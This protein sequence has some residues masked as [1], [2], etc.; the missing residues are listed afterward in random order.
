MNQRGLAIGVVVFMGCGPAAAPT[1]PTTAA[2]STATASSATPP[3]TSATPRVEAKGPI[4]APRILAPI[5]GAKVHTATPSVTVGLAAD[6]DAAEIE[7]C[8][9][10]ACATSLARVTAMKKDG[11]TSASMKALQPGR[12]YVRARG[13]RAGVVGTDASAA[14]PFAV[15][16]PLGSVDTSELSFFEPTAAELG[17]RY[18]DAKSVVAIGDVDGDGFSDAVGIPCAPGKTDCKAYALLPGGPNA[19]TVPLEGLTG[20]TWIAVGDTN[21]DGFADAVV[22]DGPRGSFVAGGAHGFG[23]PKPI[24]PA[25]GI[26]VR[27]PQGWDLNG[28]GFMDYVTAK[29]PGASGLL[30]HLG[31]VRGPAEAPTELPTGVASYECL[32]DSLSAGDINGDGYTDLAVGAYCSGAGRAYVFL[33]G[34]ALDPKPAYTLTQPASKTKVPSRFGFGVV[35]RDADH[36]GIDDLY[37]S[38]GC[39]MDEKEKGICKVPLT[40]LY[41]ASKDGLRVDKPESV[42]GP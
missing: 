34:R 23:A 18:K 8:S 32:A 40:Y 41:H 6:T 4:A 14:S 26:G 3:T 7:L 15:G 35:L 24:S 2:S 10:R 12:Y 20:S 21:G 31:S 19:A 38:T 37:V 33:G 25:A 28:D 1:T 42:T 36:D 27:S 29:G 39:Y 9:D 30:V 11:R 5:A 17:A 13:V 22:S 16:V